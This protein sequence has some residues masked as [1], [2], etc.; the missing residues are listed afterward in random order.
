MGGNDKYWDLVSDSGQVDGSLSK[1]RLANEM[2]GL[3]TTINK[4]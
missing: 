2:T 4:G 3:K 1:L